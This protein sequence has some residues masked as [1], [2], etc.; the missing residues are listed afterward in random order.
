MTTDTLNDDAGAG[1]EPIALVGIGCRFPGG[2]HDPGTFWDLLVSGNDAI[3]D[4]P[5]ERWSLQRF[6]DADAARPGKMYVR[7]GGF[8]Q[9]RIDAFDALFFGIAPREAACIDPQQR[10]LLETSWEALEDAGIPH[11]SLAGSNT[12]VFIGAFT[13]DHKLTQ[14]GKM[15]RDLIGA[16]TAIGSTMTILSNRISYTLDLRGPSVSLDTACS[17]SLVA[18]HLACQ[19]I[20]HGECDLALA[21]GVNVMLRPEYPVAMCKGGFLAPDGRSKSFDARANGYGRGEGAGVVVLKPLSAALADR[22]DIYALVRGTGANQDGRTQGITV[23]NPESQATLIRGVCDRYG[24][25]A[26][27]IRYFE[28]HGTGTPVGDP[29]EARALGSVVGGARAADDPCLVGSVKAA[30]GHLEAAAGVAGVIKASLCLA[31]RQVPPQANLATPNPDI[32]FDALGLRL[33]RRLEPL[34]SDARPL[35]AGVNSFGYGGTNAHAVLERA[36]APSAEDAGDARAEDAGD[37]LHLL[38][39]SARSDTALKDL[40]RAWLARFPAHTEA[41]ADTDAVRDLCYSASCRRGHHDHRLAVAGASWEEMRGQLAAFVE[42]GNGPW[43]AT[44]R[45]DGG[46]VPGPVFVYTGMGP[47][48]WAMGR[49]LYRHEPVYRRTVEACDA[50]FQGL[51]GWSILAEML[52]DEAHSRMADTIVA[53]PANFLIQAGLTAL[54]RAR[55]VEPAAVVGHSVGEVSAAYAAGVLSLEDSVRVSYERSRIQ[56]QAAGQGRM[57][58]VGLGRQRCTELLAALPAAG[59]S[60]AAVNGPAT[61]TLAGA[62]DALEAISAHLT[63][64]GEFNRFLQVEVAYHSPFMDPLKPEIRR[65]LA[66]LRPALPGLPLYSTVTGDRVEAIAYDAEYWC[67]NVREPV[68][69]ARAMA[70][71]LRD[72]HRVFLEIGPH[73]VLSSAIGECCRERGVEP[74]AFAS[75]RRG[76]PERHTFGLALGG[77][78]TAGCRIAWQRLYAAR[79]AYRKLPTYPWQR[80]TYW[81]EDDD[82]VADRTGAPLHPLL[83]RRLPDPRPSWQGSINRQFLPYLADHQ[84]DGLVVMPA[85]AY[86]EAALSAHRQSTGEAGCVLERLA[87]HQALI[88]DA[89]GG[90]PAV[91]VSLDP[92][93]GHY[94]FCSR[95][96]VEGGASASWRTH[97][98]GTVAA[99]AGQAPARLDR[100]GIEARCRE[101]VDVAGLYDELDERGLFYG[102]FFRT[103]RQLWRG[104][105]EVLARIELH[106]GLAV[107][108]AAYLL[109]PSLLDGCFQS[110]IA[111]IAGR[112]EFFMPV[113][114]RRAAYHAAPSHAFWCHGTLERMDDHVIEGSLRLFDDDGR[115]QVE[116]EGLRCRALAA[117]RENPA[118]QAAQWRYAWQW[119]PQALVPQTQRSGCWAVFC[120]D[121]DGGIGASLCRAL[122]AGHDHPVIRIPL[123]SSTTARPL[124]AGEVDHVETLLRKA[125]ALGCAGVAHAWGLAA[126]GRT[127]PVGAGMAGAT[128]QALQALGRVFAAGADVPRL[129]VITRGVQ[130]VV[131]GDVLEGLAQSPLVGL[132]RVAF[133]E[134]PS[135]RCTLVDLD[136]VPDT[137][138]IG[139]L[140]QELLANDGEDDVALRGMQRFVHRLERLAVVS[141]S[142]SASASGAGVGVEAA[143]SNQRECAQVEA[144]RLGQ[145]AQGRREWRAMPRPVPE[146]DGIVLALEYAEMRRTE[147][148]GAGGPDG[149]FAVG[150]VCARGAGVTRWREGERVI[151]ALEGVPASH[152]ACPASRAFSLEDLDDLPH[153]DL[154]VLAATLLPAWHALKHVARVAAGETVRIDTAPDLDV[155]A[156]MHVVRWLGARPR[157]DSTGDAP[158]F[159]G[160]KDNK[161]NQGDGSDATLARA[162]LRGARISGEA[163]GTRAPA[164]HEIVLVRGGSDEAPPRDAVADAAGAKDTG[165]SLARVDAWRLALAAPALFAQSLREIGRLMKTDPAP[166]RIEMLSLSEALAFPAADED[167]AS[168]DVPHILSLRDAAGATVRVEIPRQAPF[169][170]EATYLVTGGFGGFGLE[171]AQWMVRH[172]AR[173]LVLVGRRG[174]GDEQARAAVKALQARGVRVLAAA[175]DVSDEAQVRTLLA[176]V[177]AAFPPLKGVLHAAAVLDDAPMAELDPARVARAMQAKALGA[178]HLHRLTQ[179]QPLDFF[180]LFS[181]VSALIGNAR[182]AGYAA[183]NTFLDALAAL[184]RAQ[185]LPAASINW[186]AIATGMAIDSEEVQKHLALMGM[187]PLTARQAL[188][189]WAGMV[190]MGD[191]APSQYGLMHC[192]WARWREFEPAGG[193]SPRFSGLMADA[194]AQAG[195]ELPEA[196]L[197]IGQLPETQRRA[198]LQDALAG[199]VAAILRLPAGKIEVDRSLAQMGVDSLMSAELQA[200]VAKVFGI[201]ISTLELMRASSLGQLA[202]ILLGR[203]LL[204]APDSAAQAPADGDS[205][206]DR[207]SAIDVDALL[208]QLMPQSA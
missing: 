63:G 85:A 173:H 117:E 180:V 3:V 200:S 205:L 175:A 108:N 109:H 76:Q 192:D 158:A 148:L 127:D 8:L 48:W 79:A 118:Q 201:R 7:Q 142:A 159:Q 196:C 190:D 61:V 13:L 53:Q 43:L 60:V 70:S 21:G 111:A 49:E 94:A 104:P 137:A 2:A 195:A 166:A 134:Y 106:P 9:Q 120:A 38:P 154:L 168:A 165:G 167:E 149:Y 95:E 147:P 69:F 151:A 88:L 198:A 157:I 37:A 54:W 5:A 26:R 155:P 144:F 87:F 39:L 115:L 96:H 112:D 73:P 6:Y 98:S 89:S 17:S 207:M 206:V 184:R 100:G 113:V 78:Y 33:P 35:Y 14:M 178:W 143:A 171:A 66:D 202:E 64:L 47:Q 92:H 62:A 170:A 183:A 199:Q 93:S 194:A 169:D 150:T 24:I 97:A 152:A 114:I 18:L 139:L 179:A 132:A 138:Q 84:V 46:T 130:P 4:V 86:V 31:H 56:K 187:H 116:I 126:D 90:E 203:M 36:P 136:A 172:G 71:L 11:E 182:Q 204:P 20:W 164:L 28:A 161:G 133:N 42:E 57:L 174:A 163:T 189:A 58:A 197:A 27:D 52:A 75:L 193:N 177:A 131:A 140:R 80:E 10:L 153:T 188:D 181:S 191:A 16:H 145:G 1:P 121:D 156:I 77:L 105:G 22:D 160:N 59:V 68:H 23:P 67:D 83:D 74:R 12:G 208:A 41:D 30:I 44:G 55:G 176:N 135:L 122:E 103:I 102:P 32:P 40:A 107:D 185:G 45:A 19:A 99:L 82:S 162:R 119:Q 186:G 81:Q 146:A 128:L 51:A 34:P 129:Y 124:D 123:P 91:H 141:A 50:V 110:L 125:Q 101:A 25:D 72:G 65:V 29:L 15:N